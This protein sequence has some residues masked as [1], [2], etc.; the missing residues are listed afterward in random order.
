MNPA[1]ATELRPLHTDLVV[2]DGDGLNGYASGTADDGRTALIPL[3]ITRRIALTSSRHVT[4]CAAVVQC[5]PALRGG[6]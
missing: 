6:T 4:S 5:P 1:G 2:V 3:A